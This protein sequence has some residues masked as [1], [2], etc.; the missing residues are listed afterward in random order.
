MAGQATSGT[1][2]PALQRKKRTARLQQDGDSSNPSIG[3]EDVIL[4]RY[5][6]PIRSQFS[7]QNFKTMVSS[8]S[9]TDRRLGAGRIA[10]FRS[11]LEQSNLTRSICFLSNVEK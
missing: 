1:L 11:S 10:S 4:Q 2:R 7:A 8:Q 9:G 6:H 3:L 5:A